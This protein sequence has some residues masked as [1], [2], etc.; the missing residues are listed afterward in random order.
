MSD[1]SGDGIERATTTT[2]SL[3]TKAKLDLRIANASVNLIPTVNIYFIHTHIFVQSYAVHVWLY[4]GG[5]CSKSPQLKLIG[6]LYKHLNRNSYWFVVRNCF[7]GEW[8]AYGIFT[9]I[10][11]YVNVICT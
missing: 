2:T 10:C 5:V 3:A 9:Y 6:K 11:V 1:G 7:K 8:V 4:V